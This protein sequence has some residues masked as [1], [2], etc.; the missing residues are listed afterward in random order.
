MDLKRIGL[1]LSEQRRKKN[2][3]QK[4]LAIILSVSNQ[5]ISKWERGLCYPD[6]TLLPLLCETLGISIVEF[7]NGDENEMH[8]INDENIKK[9]VDRTL[10]YSKELINKDRIK[11]KKILQSFIISMCLIFVVLFWVIDFNRYLSF[12]KPLFKIGRAHV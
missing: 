3:T 8:L 6:I 11:Q 12:E 5:A 7:L 10:E 1:F 2:M 4:E 9:A